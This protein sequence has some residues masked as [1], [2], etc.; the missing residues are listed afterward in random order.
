MI[1]EMLD[2]L[3]EYQAQADLLALDK[4]ALINQVKIPAEVLAAQDEANKRRQ[5]IDSDFQKRQRV[6]R[7]YSQYLMGELIKPQLPPEYVAAMEKY[8]LEC[9]A[10]NGQCE[11]DIETDQENAINEKAKIDNDLQVKV[12][13]VYR[14]AE[15]R[16]AEITAE[17]A[18][19]QDAVKD[20]I[21]KL[22]QEI[23]NATIQEGKTVKGQFYQAV[24][25]RGRVT[26]ITDMLDGMVIA[27]PELAK[28][29]KEGTPSVTLRKI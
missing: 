19:K 22:T 9:E 29:R 18:D 2:R 28:A 14:Q 27:F 13:D 3:A 16:K 7:E 23:K 11:R 5:A 15:T 26:W 12:A 1:E 8:R 24:Y 20:N 6:A 17:F 25:V 21:D 4:Q 10:I